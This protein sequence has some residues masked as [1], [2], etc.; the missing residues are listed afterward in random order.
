MTNTYAVILSFGLIKFVKSRRLTDLMK[1]EVLTLQ[2]CLSFLP[3]APSSLLQMRRPRQNKGSLALK[4]LDDLEKPSSVLL[5]QNLI[6]PKG[7]Y[8]LNKH[9]KTEPIYILC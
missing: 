8:A 3:S 1:Y 2:W 6:T 9:N 5:N 7:W 4:N